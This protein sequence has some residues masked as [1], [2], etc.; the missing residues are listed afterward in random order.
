MVP[1]RARVALDHLAERVAERL[2]SIVAR[3]QPVR[4]GLE[5]SRSDA[6]RVGVV[7]VDHLV[8]DPQTL[9]V[10]QLVTLDP[11][12]W[13]VA[14]EAS[15]RVARQLGHVYYLVRVPQLLEARELQRLGD[16]LRVVSLDRLHQ[17]GCAGRSKG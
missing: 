16:A 1:E 9:L 13:Q 14:V 3:G 11:E 6:S 2:L 17:R 5:P 7:G 10:Q 12:H 4:A 15:L 8:G